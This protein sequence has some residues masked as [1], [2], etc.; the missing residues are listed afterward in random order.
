MSKKYNKKK[1]AKPKPSSSQT[2]K[3]SSSDGES[4]SKMAS[5]SNTLSKYNTVN[6]EMNKKGKLLVL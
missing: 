3:V 1:Y 6:K 2:D 5:T 4:T